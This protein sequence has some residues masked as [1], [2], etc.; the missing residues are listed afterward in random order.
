MKPVK[1]I[2]LGAGD[3][4]NAYA[5]YSLYHGHEMK[6][7]GVAEP[8][9]YYRNEFSKKYSLEKQ[10]I[11]HTYEE[12]LEVKKFADAIIIATPDR[13]HYLPVIKSLKRGYHVLVEKPIAVNE[14]ECKEIVEVSQRNKKIV[15]VCHVLRHTPYFKKMKEIIDEG[16]LGGIISIEHI[17]PVGYWHHAHSY[18]RGNWRNLKTSSPMILAKSCHDLDILRWLVGKPFQKI[19]SFGS[20]LHFKKENAPKGSAARCINCDIEED[21]P[22]SALKLYLDPEVTGWPVDVITHDLT[23]EGRIRALREGPY[24]RCVYHCDNDAV[25]HQVVCIEF[26]GGI[27]ASF[28]MSAFTTGSRRTRVMGPLGEMIGDS[29]FIEITLFK[30]QQKIVYDTLD[31]NKYMLSKHAGFGHYGGDFRI[32]SNFIKAIQKNDKS[33]FS[34]AVE[35]AMESHLMAFYAEDSR[36]KNKIVVRQ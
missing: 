25:D 34:T 31:K 6:I 26:E 32:I 29:R 22:Y 11:F 4:G 28:T 36:L 23:Y 24:G 19:A 27:T 35:E 8:R 13:I 14:E 17:E 20:L 10:F 5:E 16:I 21:C 7:V 1:V 30:N 12:A 15:G 2:V 3:R 33:I 9:E 18:V